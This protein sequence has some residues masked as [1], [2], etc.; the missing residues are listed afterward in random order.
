MGVMKWVGSS[1]AIFA[2]MRAREGSRDVGP[3]YSRFLRSDRIRE[4]QKRKR[5]GKGEGE[6]KEKRRRRRGK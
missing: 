3:R 5:R 1:P 2:M 6:E 4:E